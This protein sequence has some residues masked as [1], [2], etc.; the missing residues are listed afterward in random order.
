MTVY[1]EVYD[2]VFEH[3]VEEETERVV[4]VKVFLPQNSGDRV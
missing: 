2:T 1:V 3:M 4:D